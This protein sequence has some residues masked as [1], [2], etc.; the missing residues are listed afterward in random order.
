MRSTIFAIR[1][2]Q[3]NRDSIIPLVGCRATDRFNGP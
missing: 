2:R 3:S 1:S